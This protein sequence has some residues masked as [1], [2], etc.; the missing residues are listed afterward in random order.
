MSRRVENGSQR[1]GI[2]TVIKRGVG[3]TVLPAA[4]T[5]LLLP[6]AALATKAPKLLP[7]STI[8]KKEQ[9]RL[10]AGNVP[11]TTCE[12]S[13]S[14]A[15]ATNS[16]G[17]S[18][19]P[20]PEPSIGGTAYGNPNTHYN[21]VIKNITQ[22]LVF[23]RINPDAAVSPTADFADGKY[24]F[25]GIIRSSSPKLDVHTLE[26]GMHLN[27]NSDCDRV[28][29]PLDNGSLDL[30]DPFVTPIISPAAG[31]SIA[32]PDMALPPVG[33]EQLYS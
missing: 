12:S 13:L 28:T 17:A 10:L 5:V 15:G 19:N 32:V 2:G 8:A 18:G 33:Y 16:G 9:P 25:A 27:I 26:P 30:E 14:F 7:A 23:S 11:F 1:L 24:A 20:E 22:L 4:A 6:A 31:G 21:S 29:F 3:R